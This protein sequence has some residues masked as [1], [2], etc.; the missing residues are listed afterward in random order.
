M[1]KSLFVSNR[2]SGVLRLPPAIGDGGLSFIKQCL[3][4]FPQNMKSAPFLLAAVL[5]NAHVATAAEGISAAWTAV[6]EADK[7]LMGDYEGVWVDAPKGIYFD[8]V[9]SLVAEVVNVRD[10]EYQLRFFEQ[11]DCHADPYFEGPGKLEDG[12]IRFSGNGWQGAVTRD[13]LKGIGSDHGGNRVRFEL[14]RATRS[15]PTL[16]MEPPRAAIVLFDGRNFDHWQHRDGRPVSWHLLKNGAMEV[17]S[18]QSQDDRDRGIGGDIQTKRSFGDYRVHLEFRYPVEPGKVGQ[19]RG[20]SGIFLQR[21]YEVQILNSYGLHGYWNECGALYRTSP[22]RV[23]AARPP[24]EWQTFD[25]DYTAPVWKDGKKISPPR[26]TVR[27]NG[28]LIHKDEEIPRATSRASSSRAN[29]PQGDSPLIL[30][31]HNNALQFRNIWIL[32]A[33]E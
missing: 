25:I 13:G 28:V 32:P 5:L 16:G 11:H 31:D 8:I 26:I 14:K 6:S 19:N 22:P 7:T 3:K 2:L 29:G 24:M 10:K 27:L 15:S 4:P 20:N 17:R 23:N 18:A 30:Q 1:T 9:K 21:D 12:E 33:A